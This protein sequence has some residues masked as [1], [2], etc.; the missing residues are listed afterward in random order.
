M[1]EVKPEDVAI[2]F[3]KE[4]N[5]EGFVVEYPV[6]V[7]EGY[8]NEDDD[9]FVDTYL[10]T[11]SHLT[12]CEDGRAFACRTKISDLCFEYPDKSLNEIK[13]LFFAEYNKYTFCHAFYKDEPVILMANLETN[14]N[15][16]LMDIDTIENLMCICDND[17]IDDLMEN[18][19]EN[20][21][22]ILDECLFNNENKIESVSELKNK[23]NP[24]NLYKEVKKTVKGQDEAIKKIVT[25]IWKNYL[26]KEKANNM[27]VLGSSGVGKTEI[28]RQ[29]SKK[30]DIPLLIVSVAG[31]SQAGYKGTGTDEILSNLLTLTKGDV[32][33]AERAIVMLDEFDKIAYLGSESG[34]VST[35]GVQN[36]LLKIVED[37]KFAVEVYEN[38][39]PVKKILDTS[40]ITFVGV[41]A[42]LD[43]LTIRKEGQIG[44]GNDIKSKEVARDK[45]LPEDLIKA[46]IK[47]E[48]VGRMGEIIKLND[49][50]LDIM[51]DIIKSDKSNYYGNVKFIE[52]T[53]SKFTR[54][55]EEKIIDAIA[56]KALEGK[57]KTGARGLSSIIETMFSEVMF[58]I[59]NPDENYSEL[60]IDEEIVN[61]PKK[62]TLKK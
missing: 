49:L 46:G 23:I 36:E 6:D 47:P 42:F 44:F 41:G 7:V 52:E 32:K 61:D 3:E 62:Y 18:F 38:G 24:H 2:I 35:M 29:I 9:R 55:D 34:S 11:Y 33:K 37:G 51:K 50:D 4:I 21:D 13:D 22:E 60:I 39:F 26:N 45:I 1:V 57:N 58:D 48:L 30:L 17:D 20:K 10:Y 15:K 14:E 8:Y 5:E 59:S 19:R 28:F 12:R 16:I 43:S 27:I 40:H 56:R 31:M 25:V 53:I 54:M